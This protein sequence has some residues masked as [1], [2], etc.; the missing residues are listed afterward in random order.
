MRFH[1]PLSLLLMLCCCGSFLLAQEELP[2]SSKDITKLSFV[3]PE[4]PTLNDLSNYGK[5]NRTEG[6]PYLH[7]AYSPGRIRFEGQPNFS[8]MLDVL[9]DLEKNQLYVKLST[10]FIG[11]FPLERLDAVQVFGPQDTLVFEALDIRALFGEG[12]YGSRFY[13]ILHRGDRYLV[14]HQPIKYLRKEDYVEN[15]GMVRR[16]DKYME[17]NQY[18]VFDG[19]SIYEIK[20]NL[21]QISKVFPRKAASMKRLVN[22]HDLDL[23][24]QDDLGRLFLLLEE[25]Q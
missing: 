2:N 11:E 5:I 18:W 1:Y 21:R 16:P 9:L 13:R 4:G 17:R 20:S 7:D 14:L 25:E 22:T 19:A 23:N 10:G 8:E 6:T 15:L 24:Q 3:R 12:D